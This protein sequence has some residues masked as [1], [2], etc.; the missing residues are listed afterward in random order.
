MKID[1]KK[2]AKKMDLPE[3]PPEGAYVVVNHKVTRVTIGTGTKKIE[4]SARILKTADK[5]K[6]D[7]VAEAFIGE[8]ISISYWGDFEKEG[9][10][11]RIAYLALANHCENAF[12]PDD[13]TELVFATTGVPYVVNLVHNKKFLDVANV[14]RIPNESL[15]KYITDPDFP[16]II[17][18]PSS[19]MKD[20]KDFSR[21]GRDTSPPDEGGGDDDDG[22][23]DDDLDC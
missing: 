12:D 21:K 16:K 20:S 6:K 3:I 19:R 14:V 18:E 10:Q 9:N 23:Y 5:K 7:P 13:D 2:H 8:D 17:G 22:F 11:K 1:P 4:Y 15:D